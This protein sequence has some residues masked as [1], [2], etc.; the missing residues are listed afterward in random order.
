MD[1]TPFGRYQLL[2][3]IGRGGMGEVW[4]AYDTEFKRVVAIK[5]LPSNWAQDDVFQMRFQREAHAAAALNEPHIVPIHHFGTIDGRL[6]VDMRFIEG[7]DLHSLLR[8]GGA[9][10]PARAVMIVEQIAAALN[11]A[12][13][14]GLAHRDVKPSNILIAD[15]DFAYLIDFGL[16]RAADHSELTATGHMIGTWPYMAPERFSTGRGDARSDTYSLACVL[17]ECLTG[18]QPYPGESVEQQVMGHMVN[19]IPRPSGAGKGVPAA[20]DRVIETG[21]AKDPEQRFKTSYEMALAAKSAITSPMPKPVMPPT[22]PHPEESTQV[23]AVDP[24]PA[25]NSQDAVTQTVQR[26]DYPPHFSGPP[27][28]APVFGPPPR[29]ERSMTR[30][31]V[32]VPLLVVIALVVAGITALVATR[33]SDEDEPTVAAEQSTAAPA[34]PV[35]PATT[36]R[37][38]TDLPID[39]TFTA[40][41]GPPIDFQGRALPGDSTSTQEWS[42]VPICNQKGCVATASLTTGDADEKQLVFDQIGDQWVAVAESSGT[43]ENHADDRW[44]TFALTPQPDGTLTGDWSETW[45]S[46]GCSFHRTV[47]FTRS[48][49]AAE[50][51]VDPASLPARVASPALAMHGS[52]KY[53]ELFADHTHSHEF[54]G[55]TYCTRDGDHCLTFLANDDEAYPLV[56]GASSWVAN[57]TDDGT[58]ATT[59]AEEERVTHSEYALPQQLSDPI[60]LLSGA[61]HREIAGDCRASFDFDV[62]LERTG[63]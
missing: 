17:Y 45:A 29:N 28:P 9:L 1:G 46:G 31:R 16:A 4:R 44:T 26:R 38:R 59:G 39:G 15:L 42:I 13:K 62:S 49:D 14:A 55:Q 47:T 10:E 58:C 5:L 22:P 8:T 54:A 51:E 35:A 11:A 57:V 61:A 2:E 32:L 27:V 43:C 19:P 23:A 52:Y 36:A 25:P 50:A 56:F 21:M 30:P 60:L 6:Y 33:G 12:H 48:G 20:L 24:V 40:E 37:E 3:V 18:E 63:D 41:F 53:S 34:P 7:Q